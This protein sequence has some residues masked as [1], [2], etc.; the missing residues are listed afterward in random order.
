[1]I[2]HSEPPVPLPVWQR[3]L[4]DHADGA[5]LT[6]EVIRVLPFGAIVHFGDGIHGLMH[7]SEWTSPVEDGTQVSVRI[8]N[9]DSERRRMSLAPA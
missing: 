1:M 4:T 5:P 7:V 2:P 6:G 3:F 9:V 8:L